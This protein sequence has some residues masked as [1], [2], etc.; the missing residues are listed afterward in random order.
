MSDDLIISG[1]GT[2]AV[3]SDALLSRIETLGRL[4]AALH[5]SSGELAS[6][7]SAA[8]S[9]GMHAAAVGSSTAASSLQRVR[10]DLVAARLSVITGGNRAH[11]L[12][13]K[14]RRALEEYGQAEQ[15][16]IAASRGL[17]SLQAWWMG[18]LTGV[19]ALPAA[20]GLASAELLLSAMGTSPADQAEEAKQLL[21]AHPELITNTETVDRVR[22]MVDNT[23]DFAAG[24]FGVP[25]VIKDLLENAAG[26]SGTASSAVLVMAIANRFGLL[27]ETGV[28]VRRATSETGQTPPA[29]LRERFD[30]VPHALDE[31]QGQQVRIDR[32]RSPGRPDRFDVY[33]GGTADFN[34]ISG[35]QPFDST[36]NVAGVGQLS[37]GSYR[38]VLDAMHQAGVTAATPVQLTGYSQGGLVAALVASSDR[39]DVKG[40]VTFGAPSG[41]VPVAAGVPTLTLRNAEDLVPAA[42]GYDV[43]PHAVVVERR[44]FDTQALPIGLPVPAHQP[45]YYQQTADLTD[46]ATSDEVVRLRRSI[47]GFGA[48]AT[49]VDTTTWTAERT[50]HG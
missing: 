10:D 22:D 30:R 25:P 39:F 50:H 16:G 33:I 18:V 12:A 4:A 47:D 43:N 34:V 14:L 38:A 29:S 35:S 19:I 17:K 26:R 37:S 1:G 45:Q 28:S 41:A 27:S 9:L 32:Y 42:G 7:E 6:L 24:M 49:A 48:G 2:T 40:L 13:T 36:S 5:D 21:L 44:V 20:A 11:D 46:L 23:D 3:A 15:T 8:L 31:P